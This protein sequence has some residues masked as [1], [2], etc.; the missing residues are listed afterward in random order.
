MQEGLVLEILSN[1][2]DYPYSA[3]VYAHFL[4]KAITLKN[5][6]KEQVAIIQFYDWL[7]KNYKESIEGLAYSHLE[8]LK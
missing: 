2:K 8:K 6:S 5:L 4:S 1:P 7:L 3:K